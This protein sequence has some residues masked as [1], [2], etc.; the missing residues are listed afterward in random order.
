MES[1]ESRDSASAPKRRTKRWY[2]LGVVIATV[3]AVPAVWSTGALDPDDYKL[4]ARVLDQTRGDEAQ[5]R[6]I[7]RTY[8]EQVALRRT[9]W[10]RRHG[11]WRS[12]LDAY[13][14]AMGTIMEREPGSE[15]AWLAAKWITR[16]DNG[17]V[18]KKAVEVLDEHHLLRAPSDQLSRQPF[19]EAHDLLKRQ[20][21]L[22]SDDGLRAQARLALVNRHLFFEEASRD[23]KAILALEPDEREEAAFFL[24]GVHVL[25][26][27]QSL[28]ADGEHDAAV[29]LLATLRKDGID[30]LPPDKAELADQLATSH[31]DLGVGSMAREIVGVN[32]EGDEMRLSDFRGKVVV[33][34][35]WGHW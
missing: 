17:L 28:D 33:L 29:A 3:A 13:V 18:A 25:R 16:M 9:G 35:F 8:D 11:P 31:L 12:A 1:I 30:H 34:D 26:Y 5:V 4:V 27:A 32:L 10:R 20:V 21:E 15:A 19:D 7:A 22:H 14:N 2:I 23:A 6:A 24:G